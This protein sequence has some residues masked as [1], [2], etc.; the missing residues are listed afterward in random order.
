MA[1]TAFKLAVANFDTVD[2]HGVTSEN[3]DPAVE[4]RPASGGGSAYDTHL[5]RQPGDPTIGFSCL[6]IKAV[7]DKTGMN[8]VEIKSGDVFTSYW[9]KTIDGGFND[10][11]SV[12]EKRIVN[13]GILAI[14]SVDVSL[15][16]DARVHCAVMAVHDGTNAPIVLS[17]TNA[18]STA[19][20]VSVRWGLG[21]I[22]VNDSLV[23]GIQGFTVHTGVVV[24]PRRHNGLEYARQASARIT[25]PRVEVRTL[26]ATVMRTFGITGAALTGAGGEFFLRKLT[27]DAGPVANATAEHI[28][29]TIAN[30][31]VTPG[32]ASGDHPDDVVS[33]FTVWGRYKTTGPVL[34]I[35]VNTAIIIPAGL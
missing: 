4:V 5:A 9:T 24:T 8:L 32:V 28:E 25:G 29:F 33:G 18:P 16:D 14:S 35:T 2:F 21:P 23:E 26:D 17:G 7:L 13:K 11:A 20:S 6:D 3:V 15:L 34:P 27:Q 10:P 19:D 1:L 12:H 30:G 22:R 31:M